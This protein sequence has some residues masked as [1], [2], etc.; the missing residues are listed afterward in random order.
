[1]VKVIKKCG[2]GDILIPLFFK[3]F[4][5]H[6]LVPSCCSISVSFPRSSGNVR[7][8]PVVFSPVD[9]ERKIT[10]RKTKIA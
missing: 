4:P 3:P 5:G 9:S 7:V 10:N 2:T 8:L 1:M 6:G